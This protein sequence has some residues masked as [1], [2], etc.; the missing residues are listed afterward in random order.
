MASMSTGCQYINLHVHLLVCVIVLSIVIG[1]L[2]VLCDFLFPW[3]SQ[4]VS[5]RTRFPGLYSAL[6]SH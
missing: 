2:Q 4:L 1:V 3:M 6:R 5:C